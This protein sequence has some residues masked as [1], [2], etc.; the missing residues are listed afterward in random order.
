M[1]I[2]GLTGTITGGKSTLARTWEEKLGAKVIDLDEVARE[3]RQ[4]PKIRAKIESKLGTTDPRE[5]QNIIF[6]DEKKKKTLEELLWPDI[7]KKTEQLL[8]DYK[9]NGEEVVV[10]EG[11]ALKKTRLKDICDEIWN[12]EVREEEALKR[13]LA[14]DKNMTVS[15][16]K[17]IIKSQNKAVEKARAGINCLG[18][19]ICCVCHDGQGNILLNKRTKKCRD[20]WDCWD[21][22]GGQIEFGETFEEAIKRELME[23]ANIKPLKMEKGGSLT[24]LR[25]IRGVDTHWVAIIYAVKVEKKE[26]RSNEP[27]K[28]QTPTWFSLDNLPSPRHSHFAKDVMAVKER[29]EQYAGFGNISLDSLMDRTVAS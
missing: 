20:E 1:Q 5:L 11:V 18:V 17:K 12:V 3:V 15:L 21:N 19:S 8:K 7:V 10:I 13:L 27:E 24:V 4:I 29:L 23:E 6:S 14:R 25:K 28:L 2:I 22:W 9:K 26:Y 16:A